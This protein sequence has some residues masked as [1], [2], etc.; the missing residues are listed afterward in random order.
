VSK[1]HDNHYVPQW[2]QKGFIPDEANA[3]FYLDLKPD[4][5][6]LPDGRV[7]TMNCLYSW[8]T[9]KC[10]YQT[11]LYSTFFWDHI[12][13]EIEKKLF[14]NI[15]NTGSKAVWAFIEDDMAKWHHHFQDFFEYIDI[16]KI[17][18]PKGLDWIKS[19]YPSLTQNQLMQE[20]QALRNMHCTFWTEG[21][22]E[23][24]SAENS[25]TKFIIS[26][27]PVTIYNYA[28]P[29]D[30]SECAYPN[31]PP[32]ALKGTQT[33]FPLDQNHCLILT[34]FEY[35][36]APN[37]QIPTQDRTHAKRF[38]QSMT[39]T[40]AFIK[41]R[42][43]SDEQVTQVNFVLKSRARKYI[44]AGQKEWLY[45]EQSFSGD[46]A[47]IKETLLPPDN[48]LWQFG[49]E[50][51][52]GLDD[53]RTYY[54]DEF[55]RTT[56]ENPYLKKERPKGKLGPNSPCGCG[57][58]K[59]FKKC[60]FEKPEELR[61]SWDFL[62][63]RE[64]NLGF[65]DGVAIV[66]GLSE[67]KTWEDVRREL[68]DEQVKK[69]N[70]IFT[71]FWPIETEIFELLPKADGIV[72]ALYSGIIDPRT[73]AS[74]ALALAPYFDEIIIQNPMM[75]ANAVNKDFSPIE[76]PHMY[77]QETLKHIW[78]LFELMPFIEDGFV[79][80]IPDPCI[81][82]QHLQRQMLD[83][84]SARGNQTEISE[85]DKPL[86]DWLGHDDFFRTIWS[87]P[88][89]AQVTQIRNSDPNINNKKLNALLDH[90]AKMR[91]EDPLALMQEYNFDGEKRGQMTMLSMTPNFE[92]TLYIC[93]ITGA[94]PV[95][96]SH[97][98]WDELMG[99]QARV[100][101]LVISNWRPLTD[102][103]S[104]LT[105]PFANNPT[106]S[107]DLRQC[108]NLRD[109]RKAVQELYSAVN[110]HKE[111]ESFEDINVN[112]T[113]LFKIGHQQAIKHFGDDLE[114]EAKLKFALPK[115]GFT[116]NNVQRLL[117]SS[118]AKNFSHF[119]PMAILMEQINIL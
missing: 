23:I 104:E 37:S 5:K 55:G 54:Q 46:W 11:D 76:N 80:L 31:D 22:R 79:N 81:F 98:R 84:A 118:G 97:T 38:R 50:M 59:K 82:D 119:T 2:Y 28:L 94:F 73:I 107:L 58:A 74:S 3:L 62:S 95:T 69:I 32:V 49:G 33:L 52:A 7:V 65:I 19:N 48:G 113:Q 110:D 77:K 16:Q 112:L 6:T 60:C 78:L 85:K 41:N 51:F 99:S 105:F 96:D 30:S 17:R 18:T 71:Y 45:P 1:S 109:I 67:E 27:H 90:I 116:N 9:S 75:N 100:G 106:K 25:T 21:V 40:D 88:K 68:S 108:G 42:L 53:G 61:T 44:A 8:P 102:V 114:F 101:G 15:D 56:P 91:A 57:S 43:L 92:M 36:K 63:I 13:D 115:G 70:E 20:M 35:A 117:V 93:Q 87:L 34:N 72:R 89:E 39:R 29:P 66:L 4:Q 103:L 111:F 14:G 86:L 24:V 47:D 83:M 12:N 64:R 10:F 26:D